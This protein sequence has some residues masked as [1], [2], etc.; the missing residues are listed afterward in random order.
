MAQAMQVVRNPPPRMLSSQETL[1][2]LNH[3]ITNFRTYYRRD[4]YYKCFL[5]PDA[6]WAPNELHYGQ[7]QERVDGT[8]V[9]SAQDKSEDLCDFLNTLIGYLP[10]PYLTEK[11]LKAT[12]NLQQVWDVIREHYGLKVTSESLLDFPTL[13]KLE[14]ESHRQFYDRLMAHARLHLAGPNQVVDGINTGQHGEVMKITCH[15]VT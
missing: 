9:R 3:W 8:V 15:I 7:R 2:S 11:I 1:Y 13:H 6:T 5:L 10:F 14:D 4:S 12:T